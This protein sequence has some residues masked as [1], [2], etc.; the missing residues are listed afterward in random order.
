[1]ATGATLLF[2]RVAVQCRYLSREQVNDAVRVQ[3]ERSEDGNPATISDILLELGFLKPAQV[4][5]LVK[6]VRYMEVRAED[7]L[8]GRLALQNG[9]ITEK[10]LE[11][12]L[13]LQKKAYERTKTVPMSLVDLMLEKGHLTIAQAETIRTAVRRSRH[14]T[15]SM[16]EEFSTVP[17]PAQSDF[18]EEEEE[19]RGE[20][21][22]ESDA[23]E[24]PS[25]AGGGEARAGKAARADKK[26]G[27]PNRKSLPTVDI[28]CVACGAVSHGEEPMLGKP[29]VCPVCLETVVAQS[30][31][32]VRHRK[33]PASDTWHVVTKEDATHILDAL[34]PPGRAGASRRVDPDKTEYL[35]PS[36]L[37][38]ESGAPASSEIIDLTRRGQPAAGADDQ[39]QYLE[40]GLEAASIESPSSVLLRALGAQRPAGGT[41]VQ[42]PPQGTGSPGPGPMPAPAMPAYDPR[43]AAAAAVPAQDSPRHFVISRE[44]DTDDELDEA[45]LTNLD[46]V[47]P[48]RTATK[49]RVIAMLLEVSGYVLLAV[50]LA[51][52]VK[53]FL[54][55]D[56]TVGGLP[57]IAFAVLVGVGGGF[58]FLVA[59]GVA[60]LCRAQ[61]LLD[62]AIRHRRGR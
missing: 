51:I 16:Q 60:V 7:K 4:Q 31:N 14:M 26:K 45:G 11:D 48:G 35:D 36:L 61:A 10:V 57:K 12:C 59:H 40:D 29:W 34:P 39:T 49:L 5:A 62:H 55:G 27:R 6:A 22:D 47:L 54:H 24:S 44:V 50:G 23:V 38:R 32:S 25:S 1:M 18:D 3:S 17:V 28:Y 33:K 52:G 46:V 56:V 8:F 42:T 20:R 58:A 13:D 37:R 43:A 30:P 19:E 41:A 2:L 15:P 9:Y 21:T 53:V